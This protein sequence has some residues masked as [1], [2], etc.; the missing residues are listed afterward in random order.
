[1]DLDSIIKKLI[2]SAIIGLSILLGVNSCEAFANTQSGREQLRQELLELEKLTRPFV[3]TLQKVSQLVGPSVVSIL[4]ERKFR[5]E[6]KGYKEEEEGYGQGFAPFG[7]QPQEPEEEHQPYHDRKPHVPYH[8]FGSGVIVN[9]KGYVLTNYHL[10][11]GFEEGEITVILH[12]GKNY[13]GSIVG[14]D[15]NTDLAVLK[16]EGGEFEAAEFGDSDA[17]EVGDWVIAI[18]SPFGYQQTVSAGIISAKGRT[19]IVPT[20]KP[21]AYEDFLQTDAAINPG[22]SGGPLVNLRGEIIG[23]NT[24][25]VTRT[26]GY[27]G[28]G[29]A[30]SSSIA[31]ETMLALIEKGRVVRGYLGVGIEDINDDLAVYLNLVSTKELMAE[32]GL[33]SSEGAFVTEVWQD[34]PAWKAGILPGDVVIEIDSQ[35]V[36]NAFKLQYIIRHSKVNSIVAVK[37]IRNKT[38][39]ILNVKIEEQ[40]GGVSESAIP[41]DLSREEAPPKIN[42]RTDI[43]VSPVLGITVEELTPQIAKSLGYEH[44]TGV[45]V[46]SV[47]PGSLAEKA[48]INEGDIIS[49][50]GRY[51]VKNVTEFVEAIS[52]SDKEDESVVFLI[53]QKGFIRIK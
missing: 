29:F 18:G 47:E 33:S 21:F 14:E 34:T 30:I 32:F 26:G 43:P 50:V 2:I 4:T 19:H 10:L 6:D 27:Q 7:L 15:P 51:P 28:I 35:K 24:A 20:P 39:R 31:K 36:L 37:V 3:L 16:I 22:N 23:I 48:G 53:K 8:G 40:P 41:R 1:M 17:V 42:G 46:K 44:E 49:Q 9:E 5:P 11:E 12:D 13:E 25:I 52:K 45:V 38:E